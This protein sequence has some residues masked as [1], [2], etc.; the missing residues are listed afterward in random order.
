MTGSQLLCKAQLQIMLHQTPEKRILELR[1]HDGDKTAWLL[2]DVGESANVA[3]PQKAYHLRE[4]MVISLR[5]LVGQALEN[6]VICPDGL[7][8]SDPKASTPISP[9]ASG[10]GLDIPFSI[11]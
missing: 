7:G 6:G 5:Q 4:S 9:T 1:L 8:E 11:P 10:S 2:Y 3:H